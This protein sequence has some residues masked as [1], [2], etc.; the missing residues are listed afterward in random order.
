MMSKRAN[1]EGSIY[2]RADGRWEGSVSLGH[3]RRRRFYGKTHGEVKRKLTD[4]QKAMQDGLPVIGESVTVGKFLDSWLDAARQTVR[5]QTHTRYE[6]YVRLHAVPVIGRVSL[7]KLSPIHLQRLYKNRQD[8]GL[9]ATSVRQLHAILHRALSQAA[10]WGY[11]ARNVADL[12]SPPRVTRLQMQALSPDQSRALLE[13]AQGERFEALY[14]LALTT[15][16]RRGELLALKWPHVD[17]DAG[18]VQV[19]ATLQRTPDGFAFLEPKTA[20]SRRQVALTRTAVAA[21]RRHKV[22]Q[23]EERLRC[24]HWQD[25]E[26]VFASEV[27]TPVEAA[28][29]INRSFQP[30]LTRAGL[31]RIRFHDLRHS[32]ATLLLGQGVHPKI[33][34]EMLGHSNIAITLDLYSHVTPTMQKQAVEAL[35]AVLEG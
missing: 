12:V 26:L 5:P 24:P 33:V 29:L 10:R 21:L 28:N 32:A 11:V 18:M 14:V 8:G 19:K 2:K 30:L 22:G 16:M 35:D 17:L 31:P 25:P 34:S 9:S 3:G 6:Q 23:L 27:G 1:G 4:V 15:G 20:R 13:A 7:S